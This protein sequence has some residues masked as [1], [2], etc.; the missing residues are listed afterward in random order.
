VF[1]GAI[2]TGSEHYVDFVV[3]SIVLL[4]AGY[5]AATTSVSVHHDMSTGVVDRFRS[6]PIVSSALLTGHVIASVLRNAVSTLLVLLVALL[7][8]FQPH[9]SALDWLAAAGLLLLFMVT[10]SWLAAGFGLIARSAEAAGAFSFFVLFLP[11][12]S[13]AFVPPESMPAGLRWIA[14]RQPITALVDT[15][16]AL[17]TGAPG[18]D[19]LAAV[20]WCTGATLLG[21][22]GATWLYRRR[23]AG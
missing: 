8:G 6:L 13:S 7:I 1:G 16:R 19:A 20:L 2:Q 15:L 11:Y 22:A 3:P 4:C 18:G 17:T 5:G 23:T 9:A 14:E 10:I 12:V 21:C